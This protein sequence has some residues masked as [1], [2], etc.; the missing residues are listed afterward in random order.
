[1]DK[2]VI[3][4]G[5]GP[6]STDYLTPVVREAIEAS[7]LLIGGRRNLEV[8]RHLQKEEVVIG[9]RLEAVAEVIRQQGGHRNLVVLASGDPGIYSISKT[10]KRLLP[11]VDFQVL[12]GIS[13]LQ[14]LCARVNTP[15]ED[16]HC[17]S[18]H[19]RSPVDVA[20]IVRQH[21]KT[22]FFTGGNTS[23]EGV[24]RELV[25][26][27]LKQV[28]V[29]VGEHL[30]YPHERVVLGSP[31]TIAALSFESLSIMLVEREELPRQAWP[32][33]TPGIS[34]DRFIR[35][36]VPM[37]KEEIRAV[38][39]SK[40]RLEKDSVVYDI[41]AGTGS[42]AVECAR[43][44][45]EGTV[46]AIE[47]HAPALD[48][49]RVNRDQFGVHNLKLVEGTAPEALE[50]LPRADRVFVGG[51][52]G[53][54]KALLHTIAGWDHGCRVVINAVVIE[55]VMEALEVLKQEGFKNME[56][57]TAAFSRGQQVGSRH[58][59]KALNPVTIISADHE[60][61]KQG[62]DSQEGQV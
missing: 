3:I 28:K 8:F 21:P 60:P 56:M 11:E 24:S 15:W 58:L 14:V 18:L 27:G 13:S 1:M 40:L 31:E 42:V 30:T 41:G 53:N 54:M 4:A 10:L 2:R 16:V 7:D 32:Y 43:L 35:G 49:V 46:Y 62:K 61:Q 37:T 47:R 50:G 48:L 9:S 57:I 17:V 39:V 12:P 52:G 44:V 20:A 6:G 34:D 36:E 25:Q 51:T 33:I 45:T 38:T 23:P 55:T 26:K 29:A 19:G 59:M 22:A 5:M